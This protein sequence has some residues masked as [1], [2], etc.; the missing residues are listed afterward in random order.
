MEF[1]TEVIQ[2]ERPDDFTVNAIIG[3]AHFMKTVDDIFEA[4]VNV[5]PSIKFGVA[6]CEASGDRRI[7]FEGTDQEMIDLAVKNAQKIGAGHSFVIFLGGTFPIN[8]MHNLRIVPEITSIYCATSNPL[9]IIV[10]ETEQGRGILGVIDGGKPTRIE[11]DTDKKER[12]KILRSL[13]Y[14]S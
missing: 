4:I 7:L 3:M 13:G 6:F 8:I 11:T 5:N 2:L 12:K 9:Q 1:K 10:G 14:K